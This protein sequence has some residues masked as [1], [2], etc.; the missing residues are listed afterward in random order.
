MFRVVVYAGVWR[1]GCECSECAVSGRV[2]VG[3]LNFERLF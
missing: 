1:D 3:R 2:C